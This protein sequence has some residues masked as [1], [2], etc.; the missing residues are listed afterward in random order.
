MNKFSIANFQKTLQKWYI[1][2]SNLLIVRILT[3]ISNYLEWY[4]SGI[5]GKIFSIFTPILILSYN[6]VKN[7]NKFI[8]WLLVPFGILSG[9]A[10]TLTNYHN[11]LGNRLLN[12]HLNP[13]VKKKK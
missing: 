10:N 2:F 13:F 9:I 8:S 3:Y 11:I 7:G 1:S 5:I 12:P 4:I 6:Q